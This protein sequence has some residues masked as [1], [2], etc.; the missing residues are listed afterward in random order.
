M[1][2]ERGSQKNGELQRVI[3]HI[4][5]AIVEC[6]KDCEAMRRDLDGIGRRVGGR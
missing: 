2:N 4:E 5:I 1:I 3:G 6:R